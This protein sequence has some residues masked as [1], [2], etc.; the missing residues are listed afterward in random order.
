M[1]GRI[2]I[3]ISC[4]EERDRN[5]SI[6]R[7][8]ERGRNRDRETETEDKLNKIESIGENLLK[9]QQNNRF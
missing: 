6:E 8:R 3:V 1:N 2:D 9:F 7:E 4:A 5:I